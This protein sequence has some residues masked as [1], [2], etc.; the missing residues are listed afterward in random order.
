MLIPAYSDYRRT[1]K[2]GHILIFCLSLLAALVHYV[3]GLDN[4]LAQSRLQ[5]SMLSMQLDSQFA[6]IVNY[7]QMMQNV[8]RLKWQLAQD[9]AA[10]TEATLPILRLAKQDLVSQPLADSE[11]TAMQRAE[12]AML[13]QLAPYF[14]LAANSQPFVTGLYYVSEQ[15]F[16]FHGQ[17][18]WSDYV[19]ESLARWTESS[20]EKTY[21][22]HQTFYANFLPEQSALSQP[23]FIDE[24]KVG[25][26]ILAVQLDPML[27]ALQKIQTDTQFMLLDQTG[28]LVASSHSRHTLQLDKHL[29]QVQ[30]LNSAP[31][32]LAVLE[33]KQTLLTSGASRFI[34]VWLS[35]WVLLLVMLL[36][37]QMRHRQKVLSPLHRLTLHVER[38]AEAKT[39]VRHIPRGWES[40]FTKINELTKRESEG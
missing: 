36:L 28:E 38:L 34:A 6:P 4:R 8:A 33:R 21:D 26:F 35:Y 15:G 9:S 39:G 30:R 5:L 32:S 13:Q 16:A 10:Q 12:L 31:W 14:E 2:M 11:L 20:K 19:A 17:A 3:L 37:W 29:L 23:L 22:R 18:K 1:L 27:A 40:L 7:G 25:R 24:R